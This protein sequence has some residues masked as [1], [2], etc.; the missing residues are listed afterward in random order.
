M[1]ILDGGIKSLFGTAFGA[2]YLDAVLIRMTLVND[3]QGGT[4]EVPDEVD[5]K[6]QQD[7]I[8]D[9]MRASGGY[10]ENDARFLILQSGV[11]NLDSDCRL[12]FE[13][14]TY[15][16]ANPQQ[17]PARSYWACRATPM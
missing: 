7:A 8:T 1:G 9:Q 16:L 3:G 15:L 13:G 5:V 12:E 2:F 4:I 10:T 11:E 17:D 6:V 14:V